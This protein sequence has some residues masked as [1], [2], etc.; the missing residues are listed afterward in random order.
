[1][2][3]DGWVDPH[4]TTYAVA[5]AARALGVRI[6]TNTRVTAIELDAHRAVR[7]VVC[8]GERIET[9]HVVN[10]AGIW[11]PQVAAMVG[12]FSPSVPVD[13]QH[14][15]MAQVPGHAFPRDMPCF[16]DPDHLVYG[17]AGGRRPADRR[18]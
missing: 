5:D 13:H 4:I 10:A 2:P 16:R 7:A 3:G 11:A 9:E 12:A 18:L 15:A 17:K 14:V 1:M 8:D 6:A